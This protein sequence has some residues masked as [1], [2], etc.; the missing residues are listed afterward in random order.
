MYFIIVFI[1]KDIY[2]TYQ[3]I[4]IDPLEY[5]GRYTDALSSI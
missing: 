4:V 5:I 2:L 3:S 1:F